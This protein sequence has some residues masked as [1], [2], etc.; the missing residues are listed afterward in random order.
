MET[1]APENVKQQ[2]NTLKPSDSAIWTWQES[3]GDNSF[4]TE[5]IAQSVIDA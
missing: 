1:Q 2:E 5:R 4:Y 3:K